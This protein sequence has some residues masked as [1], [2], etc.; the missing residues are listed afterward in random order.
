MRRV[1][2][3]RLR[4]LVVFGLWSQSLLTLTAHATEAVK[5]D[6]LSLS[7]KRVHVVGDVSAGQ[8]PIPGA[9]VAVADASV[10]NLQLETVINGVS[11]GLI[12]S[13]RLHDDGSLSVKPDE[14]RELGLIPDPSALTSDGMID[15]RRLAN[16]KYV[17]D[18]AAQ[19]IRFTAGDSQRIAHHI[20]MIGNKEPVPVQRGFGA[21][22]NY[23]LAANFDTEDYRDLPDYS[24]A[25][26]HFEGR[27]FTNY[28]TLEGDMAL[29][30]T[31]LGGE[32]ATRLDTAW[33]YSDPDSQRTY[34]AGDFISSGLPWTRP[35]RMAGVQVR[36]NFALRPD[37]VTIPVPQLG[38]SAAVPSA[39]DIYLNG[40]KTYSS[41]V[42]GG[43]FVI[44]NLPA[45]TGPGVAKVV[46][47]DAA[48]GQET[49]SETRYYASSL[50]LRPGLADYA[51]ETGFARRDYGVE[52]DSYDGDII[53]N[54]SLRYGLTDRLTLEAHGEAGN[55]LLNGG[56]GVAV[57]IADWGV[58]SVAGAASSFESDEGFLAALSLEAAL[59]DWRVF[60]R[61][62]RTF[63]NYH[64][65][66]SVTADAKHGDRSFLSTRPPEALDQ[67]SLTVP[68]YFDESSLNLSLT[69]IKDEDNRSA[70]ASV[71]YDRALF[72]DTTIFATGYV[73]LSDGDDAGVYAGLMVQFSGGVMA[74]TGV[75]FSGGRD[76]VVVD[77]MKPDRDED[78]SFGWR[79]HAGLGEKVNSRAAASYVG[80][81]ARVEAGAQQYG[82]ATSGAAQMRGA[83]VAADG[84]IFLSR[85]IDDSFAVVDVGA[86][87]VEV[88]AGNR[89]VARSNRSGKAIVPR[90]NSYE[91][92]RI[93]IDPTN[94]PVD[95]DVPETSRIVVPAEKTGVV[96]DFNVKGETRSALV[97]FVDNN[98]RPL[99][100]GLAGRIGS[101]EFIV[102]YDG[103]AY[104]TDLAPTNEVTIDLTGGSQ[105]QAR[106]DF[107]NRHGEQQ[108]ISGVLCR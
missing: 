81:Y 64:D 50:L 105:C 26:G 102:G 73:D 22:V 32:Y 34:V 25:Y 47:R 1:W 103:E 20:G 58:G 89:P 3:K 33:A 76:N 7:E 99:D 9:D 66:A 96:V 54:A 36:R 79:L 23:S 41:D 46:I 68:L 24:G 95:A 37:L 69:H 90:L 29:R 70:V 17:Y 16:V 38:G 57:G 75:E 86:P 92:N 28:G 39:V 84:D 48:T 19:V 4:K 44:D 13:F 106:F 56:A 42:T 55:G 93:S 97:Q 40:V 83:L 31:P 45:I 43:P 11:R 60:M 85:Q 77:V 35:I 87:D 108:R 27:L 100:A 6:R 52:S 82:K 18:E 12:G 21:L 10:A 78:G 51:V 71:S 15:L 49:E 14:L 91:M 62:Q 88:S 2:S 61:S 5:S 74:T 67:L 101:S 63:G 30:S 107:G 104:L 53:A 94:L 8:Q 80:K 65:L 72:A 98:R 59:G